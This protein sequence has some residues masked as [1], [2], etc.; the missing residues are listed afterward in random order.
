M[1]RARP[2][3][4][5]KS[6]AKAPT[7]I[8]GLDEIT[9]GGLPKGRVTLVCGG[10]GCGKSLFA[11]EFL[12]H[13]A[14]RYGEPGVCIDFE[15]TEEKLT[16]NVASLGFDLR[17]L[18]KRKMLLVDFVA[19]E[20][21][22][23]AETGE[24]NLEGLFIR[25]AHAVKKIKAK[26]V[27]LDSIE[28]LFSGLTDSTILR[29]ELRRLFHWL[30]DHK[31][32][33]VVTGEAGEHTLT[34]HGL[35]EYIADCVISLDHRVTEQI[36]TRRMRVV[37]YRGTSHGTDEYPFLID[38]N[39]IS[40]VPITSLALDHKSPTDRV[41]TGIPALDEMMEGKGFFRGSSVLVSGTAGTGKSSLAANFTRAACA[42]GENCLYFAFE[43]SPS[44][45]LRNMR[46]VGLDL[47]QWV[48]KRLLHVHAMRPT[49]IGLEAH[50]ASVHKLIE[51]VRPSIVVIDPITN[52]VS[53]S[54][55]YNVKSMLMRLVDFLKVEQITSMFTNLTFAGDP[56][57]RTA[58]AVSSLMDTW[59]VLRDSKPN[60]RPRRE[61][62]VLKS[63]GMAHSREPRELLVSQRGLELGNILR[64][65][66]VATTAAGPDAAAPT[67]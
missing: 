25:L 7:G 20:R 2:T 4:V 59:I 37:K 18:T 19:V 60:G 67:E 23:I 24:Y 56:Q 30:E 51:G 28:A 35:E 6:I 36:S 8:Q 50:L 48:K 41:S 15:E 16:A 34:R 11:M 33:A 43:E 22:Q 27:I 9:G 26:R 44:Q 42:R 14:V 55:T 47:E 39:G 1:P 61:L 29:A 13:G 40:V 45:I 66:T 10:A 63:R 54:G 64:D 49:S 5:R 21:N 31:L 58:A 53:V 3:V 38:R 57:E 62:Y 32:T 52:L 17:A 12:A 65:H 46:S